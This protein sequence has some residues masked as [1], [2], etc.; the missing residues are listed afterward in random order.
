MK[1]TRTQKRH[2]HHRNSDVLILI[3]K[4]RRL[5]NN[6][7]TLSIYTIEKNDRIIGLFRSPDKILLHY[8]VNDSMQKKLKQKIGSIFELFL[9]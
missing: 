9:F 8:K 7:F 3:I 4:L 6:V 5:K 1:R 2:F